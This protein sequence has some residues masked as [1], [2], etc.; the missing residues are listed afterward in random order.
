MIKTLRFSS[1]ALTTTIIA[2][3]SLSACGL[4]ENEIEVI[5]TQAAADIYATHT[6]SAPT[7]TIPP[8]HTPTV[9]PT[10]TLTV[11]PTFSL[12]ITPTPSEAFA[13]SSGRCGDVNLT[14][15][16]VDFRTKDQ[17]TYGWVMN[18]VQQGCEFSATEIYYVV[19]AGSEIAGV[20]ETLT[21][22]IDGDKVRVCYTT[23]DICV[24]LVIFGNGQTLANGIEDWQYEKTDD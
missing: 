24:T 7:A 19:S 20:T 22:R 5:K 13:L 1:V 9:T 17:I 10:V 16:Y 3:V 23:N 6:A 18:A 4:S 21:G 2:L 14:G 11:T 8:T 12:P 15:R